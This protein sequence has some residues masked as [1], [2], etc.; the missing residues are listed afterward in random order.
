MFALLSFSLNIIFRSGVFQYFFSLHE[1]MYLLSYDLL[2]SGHAKSRS[3]ICSKNSFV[4]YHRAFVHSV[5]SN[6]LASFP[7]VLLKRDRETEYRNITKH[8]LNF[9]QYF[10]SRNVFN[11]ITNRRQMTKK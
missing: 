5:P 3:F 7:I 1:N 11:I 9:M 4:L 2:K 6:K 10:K 8:T